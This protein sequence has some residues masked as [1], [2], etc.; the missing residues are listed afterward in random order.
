MR[1]I[2][3]PKKPTNSLTAMV[4]SNADKKALTADIQANAVSSFLSTAV[5][6]PSQRSR[7]QGTILQLL[8]TNEKLAE[9]DMR[10]VCSCVLRGEGESLILG[11]GYY[12]VPYK[13]TATYIKGYKGYIQQAM[14]T[15]LYADIDCRDVREGEYVGRDPRT[16][17]ERMRFDLY[18]TDKERN[19]HP[20]I[21]YYAYFELKDGMF[22][23]EY[24]SMD[25][26]LD[27][28]SSK[29]PS[30]DKKTYEDY[31]SGKKAISDN[32]SPWYTYTDM[33][34]K[35]TVLRS[36]LNSGYAP[37][38]KEAKW[39]ADDNDAG[40]IIPDVDSSAYNQPEENVIKTVEADAVVVEEK[41]VE[42]KAKKTDANSSAEPR[43][44][45]QSEVK[46]AKAE[47]YKQETIFR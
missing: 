8:S 17:K 11:H 20:I 21:G 3:P 38:A 34:C 31:V 22:R 47:E 44:D 19:A 23:G 14:A 10:T 25:E 33:M 9:C 39:G 45:S 26:L 35:K 1:A 43:T 36:L 32:S 41:P 12:V 16:G 5:A 24:W 40:F 13:T 18:P 27:H 30:F 28:A 15:K 2:Q 29:S 7:I 6:D 46:T 42:K 37:L 4:Q